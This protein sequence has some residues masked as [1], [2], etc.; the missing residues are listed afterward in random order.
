MNHDQDAADKGMLVVSGIMLVVLC[1]LCAWR[2]GPGS[3]AAGWTRRGHDL[4]S[5]G[6]A[7]LLGGTLGWS[8]RAL[9]LRLRG[10]EVSER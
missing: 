3:D 6:L 7:A 2:H 5:V 10:G 8:A 4:G 9:V 1:G